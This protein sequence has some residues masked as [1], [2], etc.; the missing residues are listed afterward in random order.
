MTISDH[1]I[2]FVKFK[3]AEKMKR[4][5]SLSCILAV[6]AALA[7]E[8][9]DLSSDRYSSAN[10]LHTYTVPGFQDTKAP[11]G[12]KPFYV[13]HYGRHGSRYHLSDGKFDPALPQL[14]SLHAKALLTEDGETFRDIL[15]W[16]KDKQ[17]GVAGILT[18]VGSKEHQGIGR[19]LYQRCPS[20]FRQ[21]DRPVVHCVSSPIQRC[22]QSMANF[23]MGLKG[24]APGLDFQLYTG[25]KYYT[26]LVNDFDKSG[27]VR[28]AN[29]II[30]SLIL[31]DFDYKTTGKRFIT[32]VQT[33]ESALGGANIGRLLYEMYASAGIIRCFDETTPDPF[34]LFTDEELELFCRMSN[35]LYCA[36]YNHSAEFGEIVPNTSGTNILRDIM[37]KAD[38]AIAG[39][40]VCADLRFG[41]DSG[42]GPLLALM[43][44]EGYDAVPRLADSYKVWPGWKYLPMGSNFEMI[45]YRNGKDEVLVKMLRNEEETTIPAIS[46]YK[47]PYYRWNDLEEYLKSRLPR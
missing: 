10:I 12:F 25:E 46:T 38:A 40:D 41:H 35:V 21:K 6:T 34:A 30:D 33:A 47:G 29:A 13:S 17:N 36:S 3:K 16:M 7:Q 39:N 32:D 18:Q 1:F 19:R 20:I 27:M 5:I 4:L 42:I 44:V 22:I 9:P 43:G 23:S 15:H 26:L 8:N 24:K 2:T 11:A 31:A 45:F 37:E 28:K 14:D